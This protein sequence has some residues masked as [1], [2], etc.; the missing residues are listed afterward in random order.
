M[1]SLT[2]DQNV[3][4]IIGV[5]DIQTNVEAKTVVVTHSDSVS[6]Q[7]MLEKLQKVSWFERGYAQVG[8]SSV[9]T[10]LHTQLIHSNI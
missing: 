4:Q 8:G 2:S 1:P 10:A 7:D 6:K 3:Y 5:T 9:N